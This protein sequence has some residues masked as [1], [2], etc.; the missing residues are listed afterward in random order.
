MEKPR[1][2][3][4]LRWHALESFRTSFKTM[5]DRP[6]PL[7]ICGSVENIFLESYPGDTEVQPGFGTP[8]QD[9]GCY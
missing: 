4:M 3:W 8:V 5:D 1:S 2:R 7:E 9:H 6:S